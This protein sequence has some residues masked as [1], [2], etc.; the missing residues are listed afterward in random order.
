VK[1]AFLVLGASAAAGCMALSPP[2]RDF[3]RNEAAL[4]AAADASSYRVDPRAYRLAGAEV[5]ED[6]ITYQYQGVEKVGD[7]AWVVRFSEKSTEQDPQGLADVYALLPLIAEG[8]QGF[9]VLEEGER[10]V[11]GAKARFVR[12][13]FDSPVRDEAGKPF[14]AH[15]IIAA[16]RVEESGGPVVYH[17]KLDNHGDREQ[18]T[19]EDLGPFLAPLG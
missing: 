18:V 15:G 3:A 2:E 9:Q 11:A 6:S 4:R 19:W 17:L 14:P 12:Y 1:A 7:H 10:A 5:R 16:V 13:R 8:R